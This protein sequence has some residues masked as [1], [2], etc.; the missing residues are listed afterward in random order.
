M[1]VPG[2]CLRMGVAVVD[3]VE[4]FLSMLGGVVLGRE[5]A[6]GVEEVVLVA[7]A[8]GVPVTV[9]AEEMSVPVTGLAS[10]GT[11][12]G[13]GCEVVVH[14]GLQVAAQAMATR[15]RRVRLTE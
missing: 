14:A 13:S 10:V 6:P 8:C 9:V 5:L 4:G 12:L 1:K 3:G 11:K 15:N 7:A 2:P